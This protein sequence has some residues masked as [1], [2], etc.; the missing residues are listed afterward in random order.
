MKLKWKFL[1]FAFISLLFSCATYQQIDLEHVSVVNQR[2]AI[3]DFIEVRTSSDQ[4][5]SFT[6]TEIDKT[7][8]YGEELVIAIADIKSIE[9]K[10]KSDEPASW[11]IIYL[12]FVL[13][14]LQDLGSGFL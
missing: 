10:Q 1:C 7:N 9:K 14:V 12:F 6:V 11:V 2:L 8:L 13:L 5:Y 3:G 4:E